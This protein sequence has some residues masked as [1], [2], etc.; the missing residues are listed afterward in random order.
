MNSTAFFKLFENIFASI[1]G[2][3]SHYNN[4]FFY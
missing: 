2:P 1:I 4:D 3:Y